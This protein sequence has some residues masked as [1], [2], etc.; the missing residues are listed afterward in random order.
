[1]MRTN[2]KCNALQTICEAVV[3]AG[4]G[5]SCAEYCTPCGTRTRNLRIRSPTPCPLG[6]GGLG[7]AQSWAS[8]QTA[9][10]AGSPTVQSQPS[11]ERRNRT[12]AYL[13]AP[14]VEVQS[15]YQPDSPWPPLNDLMRAAC[16]HACA[17][18]YTVRRPQHHTSSGRGCTPHDWQQLCYSALRAAYTHTRSS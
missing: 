11:P 17:R 5:T 7:C 18:M 3:N 9:Q 6:Q 16:N 2:C 14:G 13:Y 1:M 12:P 8:V 10:K 15:E 4:P